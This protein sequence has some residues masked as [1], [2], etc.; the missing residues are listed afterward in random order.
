MSLK[1]RHDLHIDA[2]IDRG[3]RRNPKAVKQRLRGAENVEQYRRLRAMTKQNSG[4]P[5]AELAYKIGQALRPMCEWSSGP[6]ALWASGHHRHLTGFL[7][8]W[9][10]ELERSMP[11]RDARR[12][13]RAFRALPHLLGQTTFD[14]LPYLAETYKLVQTH[15]DDDKF[16]DFLML[17]EPIVPAR[18]EMLDALRLQ[19]RDDLQF[20]DK[21]LWQFD[22]VWKTWQGSQTPQPR[23]PLE[24]RIAYECCSPAFSVEERERIFL[25]AVCGFIGRPE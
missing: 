19:A 5:R 14:L 22:Q 4:L 9:W 1:E 16:R 8:T 24:F 20:D 11:V 15:F 25:T 2:H 23:W 21:R 17:M 3:S 12:L 13:F 7:A 10:I 6:V 18:E